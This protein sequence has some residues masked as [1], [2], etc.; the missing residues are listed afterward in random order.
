VQANDR[1]NIVDRL[2]EIKNFSF[3]FEQTSGKKIETG[4]CILEFDKK[5]KCNYKDKLQKQIIIN[6]KTLVILQKKNKRT[7]F[8]PI[9]K[10]P[11]LNILIKDK[12]IALIQKS[13]LVLNE[14]IELVYLD[15]NQKIITV[16][17]KKKN[18]ELIG[19]IIEDDL[20]NKIYFSLEIKSINNKI[21]KDYFKIPLLN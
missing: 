1:E 11:L 21:S 19:W 6:N 4:N 10:S 12:L 9:S 13:D 15:E 8:Y 7:Y 14:N 3:N 16:F 20:K 17:F 18:Y 5:L 2:S